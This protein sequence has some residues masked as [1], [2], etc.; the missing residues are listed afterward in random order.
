MKKFAIILILVCTLMAGATACNGG[1]ANDTGTG[2]EKSADVVKKPDY[3]KELLKMFPD[4]VG[5][6]WIYSGF[7]E[8]GHQMTLDERSKV[9]NKGYEIKISGN[10]FDM[11]DGEAKGD[12]SLALKYV[13]SDEAVKEIV[14]KGEK[15]PHKIKEFE[16]LRGPL[17]LGNSWT[18]NVIINGKETELKAEILE[19]TVEKDSNKRVIKVR[20]TAKVD[21]M[22]DGIYKETRTFKEGAGLVH[23]ENTFDQNIEFIYS[24]YKI[25]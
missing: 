18:Q 16:I 23:F 13:F 5:T 3:S 8:Y 19:D 17:K 15:L 7:A 21:G 6:E 1:G 14:E 20:Y 10:I 24:L 2:S 11:S 4:K 25:N 9:A 12:F 22:P